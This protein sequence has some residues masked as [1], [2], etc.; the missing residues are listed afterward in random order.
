MTADKG[1]AA[2][3]GN[4]RVCAHP[5]STHVN[6]RLARLLSEEA[7]QAAN[8]LGL[9]D[10][11]A[12]HLLANAIVSAKLGDELRVVR[13]RLAAHL[14]QRLLTKHHLARQHDGCERA[15]RRVVAHLRRGVRAARGTVRTR[16]RHAG[17]EGA[18]GRKNGRENGQQQG[19]HL[20]QVA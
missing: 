13:Y 11:R 5:T 4:D 2:G 9:L 20:G 15:L 8:S 19:A 10:Q 7:E 6:L 1:R 18:R 14:V 17:R 3:T 16:R 12:T